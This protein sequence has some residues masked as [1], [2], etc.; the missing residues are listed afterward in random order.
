[1]SYIYFF[2][3]PLWFPEYC[4]AK[5]FNH[6]SHDNAFG[7]VLSFPFPSS[8]LLLS[9]LAISLCLLSSQLPLC[10]CCLSRLW[11][12][13]CRR[14]TVTLSSWLSFPLPSCYPG[15]K[16][17]PSFPLVSPKPFLLQESRLDLHISFLWMPAFFASL[18]FVLSPSTSWLCFLTTPVS[19]GPWFPYTNIFE[20]SFF[21][22]FPVLMLHPGT[23]SATCFICF[24]FRL[25]SMAWENYETK[26]IESI[27]MFGSITAVALLSFCA[28]PVG[29]NPMSSLAVS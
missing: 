18:S 16:S 27:E 8:F 6:F 26:M 24:V 22:T 29:P 4:S 28:F 21:L 19:S 10:V 7:F 20:S 23:T 9:L 14:L 2:S 15:V 13:Q 25:S 11:R 1:M 12:F 17:S 3:F 5:L